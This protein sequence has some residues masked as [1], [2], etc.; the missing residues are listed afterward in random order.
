MHNNLKVT[1]AVGDLS[2]QIRTSKCFSD[3]LGK[4][5]NLKKMKRNIKDDFESL[6]NLEWWLVFPFF[7]NKNIITCGFLFW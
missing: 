5:V 6:A 2:R 3:H 4:F 7:Y 1:F